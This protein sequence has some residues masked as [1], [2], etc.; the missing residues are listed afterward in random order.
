MKTYCP[1]CGTKM[2][3][4]A[5]KPK[6]CSN[7][8]YAFAGASKPK[9]NYQE[10]IETEEEVVTDLPHV[11]NQI[12]SLDVELEVDKP[13]GV[14]FG[15]IVGTSSPPKEGDFPQADPEAEIDTKQF[16]ADFLKEAGTSRKTDA[17]SKND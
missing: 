17:P 9:P 13:Q 2:E 14:Q 1:E 12:S 4:I 15:A 10:S 16:L 11:L 6:F 3:Y 7:C 5:K 8:G